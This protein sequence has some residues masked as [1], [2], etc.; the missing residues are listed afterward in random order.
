MRLSKKNVGTKLSCILFCSENSKLRKNN[1]TKKLNRGL[2][3]QWFSLFAQ[4]HIKL[5]TKDIMKLILLMLFCK[6]ISAETFAQIEGEWKLETN[7]LFYSEIF[8]FSDNGRF[9]ATYQGGLVKE[10]SEGNWFVDK[11]GNVILNSDWQP[12][13]ITKACYETLKD[14]VT[15]SDSFLVTVKDSPYSLFILVDAQGKKHN[16]ETDAEGSFKTINKINYKKIY[17][18]E[19]P[20]YPFIIKSKTNLI[21]FNMRNQAYFFITNGRLKIIDSETLHYFSNNGKKVYSIL[22]K[23]N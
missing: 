6:L 17:L 9:S 8:V 12:S 11:K 2:Y 22:K 15:L 1:Q 7:N 18:Q 21:V 19:C 13:R 20:D 16:I 10:T 14:T 4:S 23:I 5:K 3:L